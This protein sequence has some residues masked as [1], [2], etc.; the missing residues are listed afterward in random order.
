LEIVGTRNVP[1]RT[2]PRGGAGP[3]SELDQHRRS[4]LEDHLVSGQLGAPM[5]LVG[6]SR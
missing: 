5:P 3:G 2:E 1:R 6:C 4:V